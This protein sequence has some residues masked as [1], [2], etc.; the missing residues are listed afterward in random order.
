MSADFAVKNS[1]PENHTTACLQP[2]ARCAVY[3]L[4]AACRQWQPHVSRGKQTVSGN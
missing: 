3:V 4:I 1:E 2:A